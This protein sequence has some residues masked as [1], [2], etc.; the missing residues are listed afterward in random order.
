[1]CLLTSEFDQRHAGNDRDNKSWRFCP[2]LLQ[3]DPTD[4]RAPQTAEQESNTKPERSLLTLVS[5]YG[6]EYANLYN[7]YYFNYSL[8]AP[9]YKLLTTIGNPDQLYENFSFTYELENDLKA[10]RI[11]DISIDL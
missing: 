7:I 5:Y 11:C 3:K 1:M 8:F 2:L 9:Y 6:S 10:T 4:G